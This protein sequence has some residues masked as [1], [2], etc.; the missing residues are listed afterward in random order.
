VAGVSLGGWIAAEMA[1][2]SCA[3]ISHLVL[4]N[5][6]GIKALDR[7]T[8]E[9]ADIFAMM[10][11]QFNELAYFDPAVGKRDYTKMPEAEVRAGGAQPRGDRALRLVAPYA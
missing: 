3:R 1:V 5:P 9:I 10:E 6:V 11:D 4:A 2:K 7:E 8:R